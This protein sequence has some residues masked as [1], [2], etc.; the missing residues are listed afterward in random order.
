MS[1]R[2]RFENRAKLITKGVRKDDTLPPAKSREDAWKEV[3]TVEQV[4]QFYQLYYPH[5]PDILC[6]ALGDMF[7]KAV[8]GEIS[9]PDNYLTRKKKET[10]SWDFEKEIEEM[11]TFGK[12]QNSIKKMEELMI[13][14]TDE[15]QEKEIARIADQEKP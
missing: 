15:P 3:K 10:T 8:A 13:V 1:Q 2:S 14:P 5:L 6:K 12:V 11:K 4:V 9:L 7:G